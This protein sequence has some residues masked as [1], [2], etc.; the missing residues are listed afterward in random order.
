MGKA[1]HDR[2]DGAKRLGLRLVLPSLIVIPAKAGI[3]G[4]SSAA[5][6]LVLDPHFPGM[7]II[8][9]LADG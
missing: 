4:L 7:S 6:P 1:R 5:C 3:Q 2:G 8:S 9:E